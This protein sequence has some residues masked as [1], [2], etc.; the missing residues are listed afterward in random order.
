[1]FPYTQVD[2]LNADPM[3]MEAQM[4][5]MQMIEQK[6]IDENMENAME[7]TPEAFGQVSMLC[8]QP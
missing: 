1:M 4:K 6:N 2:L 8:V 7:N 5:I 3:D